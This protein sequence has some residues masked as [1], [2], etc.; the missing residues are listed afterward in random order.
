[1]TKELAERLFEIIAP[2]CPYCE[3]DVSY[4]FYGNNGERYCPNCMKRIDGDVV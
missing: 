4:V 3:A 2:K 1:M